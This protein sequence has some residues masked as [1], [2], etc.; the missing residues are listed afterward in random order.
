MTALNYFWII[1]FLTVCGW[2]EAKKP[3]ILVALPPHATLVARVAGDRVETAVVLETG[4]D[5]EVFAPTP[6]NLR[7]FQEADLY[8]ATGLGFERSFVPRL[9][10]LSP[11]LELIGEAAPG[12]GED[13]SH[14]DHDHDH[15][16]GHHDH[17]EDDPHWWL[18]P[19]EV[20]SRVHALAEALAAFDPP[21]AADYLAGA[22][23]F[24]ARCEALHAELA[25]LFAPYRGR[26]FFVYHAAFGHFAA[27][28]GLEQV[29][30]E[31]EGR[32]PSLREMGALVARGRAEGVRVV[33]A[34]PQHRATAL[35]VF[36]EQFGAEIVRLDPLAADWEANLRTLAARLVEGF[37]GPQ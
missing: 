4:G 6:S 26:S 37:G 15:D 2:A 28:Y 1:G 22:T 8:W 12:E 25:E 9:R 23:A 20:A 17:G 31:R 13:E 33:Y 35:T 21:H 3:R 29:P 27:A 16:H 19:R 5:H 36:A 32:E 18:S 24:A 34:Q 14:H 30:L 11:A 7:R 10:A